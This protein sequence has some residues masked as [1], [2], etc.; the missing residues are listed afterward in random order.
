MALLRWSISLVE[1]LLRQSSEQ[2]T[3]EL[4]TD[5]ARKHI[6]RLLQEHQPSDGPLWDAHRQRE[7][8][9]V[10]ADIDHLSQPSPI[11]STYLSTHTATD[12]RLRSRTTWECLV[13][14]CWLESHTDSTAGKL[15]TQ[16]TTLVTMHNGYLMHADVFARALRKGKPAW[17]ILRC[18]GNLIMRLLITRV[19]CSA[20]VKFWAQVGR[21]L[22]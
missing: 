1:Q 11:M 10:V 18:S 15:L 21:C 20:M 5:Y 9:E 12:S 8:G 17:H 13:C 7:T 16:K 3:G 6:V 2:D 4:R 19:L 22:T 14:V